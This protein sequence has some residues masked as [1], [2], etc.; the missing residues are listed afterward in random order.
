MTAN[1]ADF[2]LFLEFSEIMVLFVLASDIL[3]LI[4]DLPGR[5]FLIGKTKKKY[6]QNK[7]RQKK[8]L[9]I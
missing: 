1:N 5:L 6:S 9:K 4:V 8:S 3:F 2:L 7:F